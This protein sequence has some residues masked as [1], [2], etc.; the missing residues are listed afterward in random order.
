MQPAQALLADHRTIPVTTCSASRCLLF[1]PD[2]R[3][4]F[5]IVGDVIGD[6]S[7]QMP[8]VQ[9][10]YVIEQLTAAA[11]DPGASPLDSAKDFQS[12]FA[13]A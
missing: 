3:S 2:V 8:L 12:T 4:I 1:Q 11:A 7:L 9:R 5:L 10:D 6:K 13:P